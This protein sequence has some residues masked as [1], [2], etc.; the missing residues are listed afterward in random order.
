MRSPVAAKIVLHLAGAR[1][2]LYTRSSKTPMPE[3]SA[4]QSDKRRSKFGAGKIARVLL[5]VSGGGAP[6]IA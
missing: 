6:R 5:E 4:R 3:R 1:R 2:A